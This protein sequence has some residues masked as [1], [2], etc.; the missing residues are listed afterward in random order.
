MLMTLRG[1]FPK[2][3]IPKSDIVHIFCGVRPLM[4]SQEGYTSKVSRSHLLAE[5]KPDDKR[6]FPVYSMVGGK[7]TTFRAFA[8]MTADRLMPVLSVT[9]TVSTTDRYY[10][11]PETFTGEK[12]KTLPALTIAEVRASAEKELV[13]HLSDFVR[14]RSVITL[15]GQ[16]MDASANELAEIIGSVLGWD[17]SR[18]R[19]EISMA[20]A[21][22]HGRK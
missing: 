12:L 14:R 8:E 20:L 16:L 3:N 21:E 18:R 13:V 4:A 19:E 11:K 10:P 1:V 9:R 7:L 5:H 6:S 2:I 15:L 17:D 22:A